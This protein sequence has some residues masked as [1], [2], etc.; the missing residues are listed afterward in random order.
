M[1]TQQKKRTPTKKR[2]RAKSASGTGSSPR[3]AD[4]LV[5]PLQQDDK[6]DSKEEEKEEKEETEE[7]EDKEE[8][9]G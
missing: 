2:L 9:E 3:I 7:K 4:R 8:R 6:S 5:A 1:D